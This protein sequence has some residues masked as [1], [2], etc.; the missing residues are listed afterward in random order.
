MIKLTTTDIARWSVAK[1]TQPIKAKPLISVMV[2]RSVMSKFLVDTLEGREVLGDG[3]LICIGQAG[4]AWQQMP[5][6]LLAKYEVT[7][8]DADGWMACTPR[9]DNSINVVEVTDAMVRDQNGLPMSGEF[10]ILGLFGEPHE[11]GLRQVGKVGDFIGQ[12]REDSSDVW[13]I[14]RKIYLNTYQLIS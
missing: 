10:Y 2:D 13:V 7:G 8:I 14:R 12:N 1:K 11:D 9:P 4:D 5:N 3:A 6:K